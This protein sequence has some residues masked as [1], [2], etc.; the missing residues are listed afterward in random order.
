MVWTQG[1]GGVVSGVFAC[2]VI[3]INPENLIECADSIFVTKSP[4][5]EAA[6]TMRSAMEDA[7]HMQRQGMARRFLRA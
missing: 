1:I 4:K 6:G 5:L 3:V 2:I 7:R